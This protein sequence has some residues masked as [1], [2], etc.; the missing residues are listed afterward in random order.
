M[1][2]INSYKDLIVWQKGKELAKLI[3]QETRSMPRSEMFGLTAQ[4]RRAAVSIPSN[5]AEGYNRKT[6][7]EY[8]R[9]LRI[10]SGSQAELTTQWEISEALEYVKPNPQVANLL[11]EIDRMLFA[12]VRKLEQKR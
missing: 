7:P 3:H 2:Q 10:A 11:V 12:L 1:A 8:L 9:G 4:M 6:R 5:I